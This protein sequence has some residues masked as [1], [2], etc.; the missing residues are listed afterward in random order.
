MEAD[1][2]AVED[3]EVVEIAVTIVAET[4]A[5]AAEDTEVVEIAETTEAETDAEGGLEDLLDAS[6]ESAQKLGK[7]CFIRSGYTEHVYEVFY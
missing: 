2:E 4:D 1:A 6:L 3:T 5:V 7:L